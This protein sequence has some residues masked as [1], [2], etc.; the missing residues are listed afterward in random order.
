MDKIDWEKL[1]VSNP[2][3]ITDIFMNAMH[4]ERLQA[5]A[6]AIAVAEF[7]KGSSLTNQEKNTIIVSV[8]DT[9]KDLIS[10]RMINAYGDEMRKHM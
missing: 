10:N 2:K 8:E 6:T 3:G 5:M 7:Q 4:A 1:D 9:F